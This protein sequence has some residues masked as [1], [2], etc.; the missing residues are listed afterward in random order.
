MFSAARAQSV[1][2]GFTTGPREKRKEKRRKEEGRRSL[3]LLFTA[4]VLNI[5]R[6]CGIEF[7]EW[8]LTEIFG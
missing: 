5:M 6:P 2:A 4:E 7:A 1:A 8:K 3:C